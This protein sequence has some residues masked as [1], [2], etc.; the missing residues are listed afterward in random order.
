MSA[1]GA[2]AAAVEAGSSP[3]GLKSRL[4]RLRRRVGWRSV[5][6][7]GVGGVSLL[8][9]LRSV[10]GRCYGESFLS[11]ALGLLLRAGARRDALLLLTTF[12]FAI[13]TLKSAGASPI[14]GFLLSGV[15]LGPHGLGVI[16]RA[17]KGRDSGQLQRLLSRS[18][19]ARLGRFWDE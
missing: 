1:E 10:L 6:A 4:G 7:L 9:G 2:P 14:L 8:W 16:S 18:L 5:C 3:R 19:S 12:A 15:A 17:G 13:P 11:E